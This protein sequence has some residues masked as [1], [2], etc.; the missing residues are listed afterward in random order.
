MVTLVTSL[1]TQGIISKMDPTQFNIFPNNL[2]V[3]THNLILGQ[4]S[5]L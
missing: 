1:I 4:V 2:I 5:V 3:Y